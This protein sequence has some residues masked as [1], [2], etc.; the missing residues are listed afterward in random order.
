MTFA[1]VGGRELVQALGP[2]DLRVVAA[3]RVGRVRD[4]QDRPAR[5]F[6]GG[7]RWRRRGR[8]GPGRIGGE[9]LP[10]RSATPLG[11]ALDR[12]GVGGREL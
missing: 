7:R 6:V 4:D 10:A 5:P 9:G 3:E 2:Q 12:R 11:A 8:E 1:D